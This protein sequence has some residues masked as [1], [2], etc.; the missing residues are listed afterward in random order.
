MRDAYDRLCIGAVAPVLAACD[1]SKN[2][3]TLTTN[4]AVWW[5]G[6]S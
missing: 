3:A 1:A 6:V 4:L 5:G 2:E